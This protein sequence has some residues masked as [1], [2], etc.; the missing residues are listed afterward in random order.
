[1]KTASE[2]AA[3]DAAVVA[4]EDSSAKLLSYS[5]DLHRSDLE[6][7]PRL[8]HGAAYERYMRAVQQLQRRAPRRP[9]QATAIS[10]TTTPDA[11]RFATS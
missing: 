2:A 4:I 3:A 9:R 11:R 1:M 5:L 7:L 8:G 10:S 6:A